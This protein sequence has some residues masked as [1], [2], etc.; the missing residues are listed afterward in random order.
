MSGTVDGQVVSAS[1]VYDVLGRLSQTTING[2]TSQLHYDGD[3]LVG[4]YVGGI[5]TQRY[6]HGDQVDEPLVHY[7]NNA[8]SPGTRRF[9]HSDH[10]GSIIAH[11]DNSGA[12]VQ[13]NAYDSFGVPA[14]TNEGRFGYTGQA[15]LKQLGLNYYKARIYSPKLG[16]FLQTDPIFYADDMNLYAY[17]GN[18]PLNRF[19]PK[20]TQDVPNCDTQPSSCFEE[21]PVDVPPPLDPD[22]YIDPEGNII[23]PPKGFTQRDER[24]G[25]PDP[26]APP[27]PV[28]VTKPPADPNVSPRVPSTSEADGTGPVGYE[29][30]R[31]EWE[32]ANQQRQD[33]QRTGDNEKAKEWSQRGRE[34][35]IKMMAIQG[36]KIDPKV[37]GPPTE[38][39]R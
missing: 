4:E 26:N 27:G 19:D 30:A 13:T 6:V 11:S 12:A 17:V 22:A 18:D 33:A 34:A 28:D 8:V 16:R 24:S 9:L 20:G 38:Y 14:S 39:D 23:S 7:T 29:T 15:W 3:A 1:L 32:N 31:Q 36:V 35:F 2:V 37:Y 10:Q 21:I 5:L 25:P